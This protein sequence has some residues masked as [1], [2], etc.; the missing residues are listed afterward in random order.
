MC[1]CLD[2]YVNELNLLHV[3]WKR[4]FVTSRELGQYVS[5]YMPVYVSI[6]NSLRLVR[7]LSVKD[8]YWLTDLSDNLNYFV[9]LNNESGYNVLLLLLIYGDIKLQTTRWEDKL[10][11]NSASLPQCVHIVS[12]SRGWYD[13]LKYTLSLGLKRLLNKK[14]FI[15]RTV[16]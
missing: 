5:P 2:V 4:K 10:A 3:L 9:F 6:G 16:V 12:S 8:I 11:T 15:I 1:T 13:V 7:G 14:T